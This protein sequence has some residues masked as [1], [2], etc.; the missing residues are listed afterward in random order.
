MR[1]CPTFFAILRCAT[2]RRSG[3]GELSDELA[4]LFKVGKV[5]P[6]IRRCLLRLLFAI[7]VVGAPP[8]RAVE[9][10]VEDAVTAEWYVDVKSAVPVLGHD[11]EKD[12]EAITYSPDAR[13]AAFLTRQGNLGAGTVEFTLHVA[14]LSNGKIA[15]KQLVRLSSN[16]NR[17][18]ISAVRWIS[19][20]RIG[21][22][23]ERNS[24][25]QVMSVNV[26]GQLTTHTKIDGEKLGFDIG[27]NGTTV[28]G[29]S[30]L[31]KVADDAADD[32]GHLVGDKT[33]A[34]ILGI[35]RVGWRRSL[36]YYIARRGQ[37][38]RLDGLSNGTSNFPPFISISPSGRY[39][40][41]AAGPS[42]PFKQWMKSPPLDNKVAGTGVHSDH[43]V[44]SLV[45]IES[46]ARYELSGAPMAWPTN[47]T[48]I[49]WNES[50]DR[51]I[52]IDQFVSS[53]QAALLDG[54]SNTFLPATF[55]FSLETMKPA[56][57]IDISPV[58]NRTAMGAVADR[59]R[60]DGETGRLDVV[61]GDRLIRYEDT[62][63]GWRR[64]G[65]PRGTMKAREKP[66][67]LEVH[68][69]VSQS[70]QM[71]AVIADSQTPI[72]VGEINAHL[73]S[74][75]NPAQLFQ[76]TDDAGRD[77]EAGLILPK[78]AI[79]E[80]GLPLIIQT[81]SFSPYEFVITGPRGSAAGFS[82]QAL[83]SA[84]FAVLNMGYQRREI[85]A[86]REEFDTQSDGYHSAIKA[87]TE[88]G[89]VDPSRV[90]VIAWSRSG[91]WLQHAL[92]FKDDLFTAAIACDPSSFGQFYYLYFYNWPAIYHADHITQSGTPPFGDGL[93]NWRLRDPVTHVSSFTLPLLIEDYGAGFPGWWE[94]Y[95][96][97][98]EAHEPVEYFILRGA[99]HDP[100]KPQHRL[101]V[102]A[103]TV[104]WFGFWL[105]GREDTAPKKAA[106]Y[107]R[108]RSMREERC[109]RDE[110][111]NE[112]PAYCGFQ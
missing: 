91:Y 23:G 68:Q 4:V 107:A 17:P 28:F 5:M 38:R 11:G 16:S 26:E 22:I 54:L 1:S 80:D 3:S 35:G 99:A 106:Q 34:D 100:I 39:V 73:R 95:V 29:I 56:R 12:F 31:P 98:K 49:V 93:D 41:I 102:Q 108:W 2:D 48:Q 25:P 112:K 97:M 69:S 87:L 104:D 13:R 89:V 85:V 64:E 8:A 57:L 24:T 33:L 55:E 86:T 76:W 77:W 83:A 70:A 10:K 37:A 65:G 36:E 66:F 42:D 110:P 90:G 53:A 105:L 78:A 18:A 67:R 72:A 75:F 111:E 103:L 46:D 30:Q 62:P 40:V 50:H 96:A 63:Q 81:H 51:L 94:P 92:A 27:S 20:D 79:E 84:G 21:F 82:G 14:A 9:F 71:Y 101:R 19:D 7:A 60:L 47:R 44:L 45:D 88:G 74:R 58:A 109:A 6:C 59:A 15:H 32:S 43:S 61:R 52:L